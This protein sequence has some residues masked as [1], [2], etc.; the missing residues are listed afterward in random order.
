MEGSEDLQ[1]YACS[2]VAQIDLVS[3][4]KCRIGSLPEL[5]L[6]PT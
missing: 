1:I 2:L 5:G 6:E 3:K 4:E